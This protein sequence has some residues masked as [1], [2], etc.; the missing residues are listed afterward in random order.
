MQDHSND[1]EVTLSVA[2][3]NAWCLPLMLSPVQ[4]S[5]TQ[6]KQ[7]GQKLTAGLTHRD[8]AFVHGH[9]KQKDS[10]LTCLCCGTLV[11]ELRPRPLAL[12]ASQC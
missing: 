12:P 8:N 2:T 6:T 10:M 5:E 3:F 9:G 11:W 4:V 7:R 1:E